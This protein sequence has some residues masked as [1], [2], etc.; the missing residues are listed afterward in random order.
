MEKFVLGISR[1]SARRTKAVKLNPLRLRHHCH[2][3]LQHHRVELFADV[4]QD[5]QC[6][7]KNFQAE[8]SD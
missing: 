2:D 1:Y 6:G 5:M 7:I 8:I 4:N 3:S